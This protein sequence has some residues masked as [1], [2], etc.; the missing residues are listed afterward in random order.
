[1]ASLFNSALCTL[2]LARTPTTV[3]TPTAHQLKGMMIMPIIHSHRQVKPSRGCGCLQRE[4]LP[5]RLLDKLCI[6]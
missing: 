5:C 3:I 4:V 6:M 1:M 2:F